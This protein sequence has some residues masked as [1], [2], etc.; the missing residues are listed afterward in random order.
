MTPLPLTPA[1][2]AALTARLEH[3]QAQQEQAIAESAPPSGPGDAADRTTH[4]EALLRLADL[5]SRIEALQF[6]LQAPEAAAEPHTTV[7]VGDRVVV[8]WGPEE[9]PESYL[10]GFVEQAGPEF[11]VIT[12]AS[13][14]GKALLG[15]S[16]G[17]VVQFRAANGAQVTATLLDIAA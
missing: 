14:L 2:R 15:A 8:R 12:P 13:P 4:I 3:L 17:D 7:A 1:A 11:D 16:P 10:V 6:Q 9:E 5:E